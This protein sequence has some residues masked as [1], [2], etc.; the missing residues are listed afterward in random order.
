MKNWPEP[1]KNSF[2][3]KNMIK[4]EAHLITIAYKR[5]LAKICINLS[6]RP[7]PICHSLGSGAKISSTCF[8]YFSSVT[9]RFSFIVGVS[10]PPGNEKS[11]PS[12]LNFRIWAALETDFLFV[13]SI[14]F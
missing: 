4:L 13:A 5:N 3:Y 6:E 12:N 8:L 1:L 10:S 9:L 7:E 2:F 11:S 14:Q